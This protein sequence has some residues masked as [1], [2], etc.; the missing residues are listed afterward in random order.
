[1]RCELLFADGH[2]LFVVGC[3]SVGARCVLFAVW[4]LLLCAVRLWVLLGVCCLALL[5]DGW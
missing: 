4:W 5:C 2:L 3:V 1:M